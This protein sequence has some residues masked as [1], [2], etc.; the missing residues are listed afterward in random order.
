MEQGFE[1]KFEVAKCWLKYSDSNK[2]I[3]KIV[4]EKSYISWLEL[5]NPW[6]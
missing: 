1:A 5:F 4:Q 2:T 6:L 3:V